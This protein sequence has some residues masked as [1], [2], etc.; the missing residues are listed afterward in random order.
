MRDFYRAGLVFMAGLIMIK[1]AP[2][3]AQPIPD[4][5]QELKPSIALRII[6]GVPAQDEAWPWH[7]LIV[8]PLVM[9]DGKKVAGMCGGSII[10]PR[11]VLTA[12]HCF[13]NWQLDGGRSIEVTERR[14]T[15]HKAGAP[16]A[17]LG[18]DDNDRATAHRVAKPILHPQ[19]SAA[20]R[21]NDI[22]LLHLDEPARSDAVPILLATNHSLESPPTRTIVTGWGRTREIRPVGGGF[23]DAI[24]QM[25]VRPQDVVPDRLMEVELPL[26]ATESCSVSHQAAGYVIDGRNLCAGYPEGGKDTCQGDSGG[27]M[28]VRT[29][30][31]R[32]LQIGVVDWGVGCAH[33]N[34]PGVYTRVSVFAEWIKSTI[35]HDLAVT[36]EEEAQQGEEKPE[37]PP[38]EPRPGPGFDNA[39]GVAIAFDKGDDVKVGDLVSYR[40][41]ARKTGY[42]AIFDATPDGK[43]TQ[44]FPNARS[45]ASP[46]GT[47]PEAYRIEPSRPLIVPDYRNQY[48]GFNVRITEPRGKGLMV[49]VL[50]DTPLRSL[51]VPMTPMTFSSQDE[52]ITAIGRLRE[53]LTRG[54]RSGDS[55]RTTRANWSVVTHEYRIR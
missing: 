32:W 48:R 39:A 17:A 12:A 40:V 52:A 19:Y 16:G 35:G 2:A 45:L 47:K 23:V 28:V 21:E 51:E 4:A 6:G 30:R 22:A 1:P 25:R 50:S 49:A 54:Q 41:T 11:W 10:G 3:T 7:V 42:L 46:T 26:V 53:E 44:V 5:L 43:L 36:P 20:S 8:I 27:A 31:S 55:G 13:R 15:A 37:A 38:S 9:A 29:S 18:L 14:G 24:T 33:K 34:S